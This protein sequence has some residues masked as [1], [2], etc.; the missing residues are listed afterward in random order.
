MTIEGAVPAGP[1][2]WGLDDVPDLGGRTIVVTGASSGLGLILTRH[3]AGSGATVVM[4]VRDPEKG[5][6]VR[7][8]LMSAR[9]VG[10]LEVRFSEV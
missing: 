6:R 2:A 1:V 7:R 3:L 9:P 4:A 5:G 10:D 8:E